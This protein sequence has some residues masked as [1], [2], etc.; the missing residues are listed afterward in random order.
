MD[1]KY[2]IKFARIISID[3]KE[4]YFQLRFVKIRVESM[5]ECLRFRRKFG[6]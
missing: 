1:Q 3:F 5:R 4:K 6:T 2:T